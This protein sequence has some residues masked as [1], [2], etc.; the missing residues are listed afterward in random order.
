MERAPAGARS[1]LAVTAH[2]D[3][4]TLQEFTLRLWNARR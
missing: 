1:A 4:I 2:I 3:G